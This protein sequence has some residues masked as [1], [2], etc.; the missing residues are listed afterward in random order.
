M[1]R[2]EPL[3]NRPGTVWSVFYQVED[4]ENWDDDEAWIR[5][6]HNGL[7][8]ERRRELSVDGPYVEPETMPADVAGSASLSSQK[9]EGL[10]VSAVLAILMGIVLAIFG[11]LVSEDATIGATI[12][13]CSGSF[14]T[15]LVMYLVLRH[16]TSRTACHRQ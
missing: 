5:V 15:M 13:W 10:W 11:A 8:L 1:K 16:R 6:C 9:I 14:P 7:Y 3:L 12:G 4:P 2:R